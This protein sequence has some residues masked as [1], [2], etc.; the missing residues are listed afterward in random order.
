M[1][2]DSLVYSVFDAVQVAAQDCVTIVV[3]TLLLT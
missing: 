2:C 1:T 3:Q